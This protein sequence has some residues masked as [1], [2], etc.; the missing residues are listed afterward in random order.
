[1]LEATAG[2]IYTCAYCGEGIRSNKKYCGTCN[3]QKG[4]KEIFDANVKIF[5]QNKELGFN[6]P[7]TL[8]NWK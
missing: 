5:K 2:V 8:K 4:R 6:T 1:M 7:E 3:T